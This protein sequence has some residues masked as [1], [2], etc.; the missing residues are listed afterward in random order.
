MLVV[1]GGARREGVLVCVRRPSVSVARLCQWFVC[2]SRCRYRCRLRYRWRGPAKP[3]NAVSIN[4]SSGCAIEEFACV[5]LQVLIFLK[6]GFAGFDIFESRFSTFSPFFFN[7]FLLFGVM[8]L[9]F[10]LV[11][12]PHFRFFLAEKS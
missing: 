5:V 7:I 8:V 6:C 11:C 3:G 12:C 1:R 10:A 4:T 9:F 2:V